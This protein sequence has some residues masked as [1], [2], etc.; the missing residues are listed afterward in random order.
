MHK[1]LLSFLLLLAL[2]AISC[3]AMAEFVEFTKFDIA[4]I[5]FDKESLVK[6]GNTAQMWIFIASN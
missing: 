2:T 5:Y 6:K 4:T 3:N 1:F